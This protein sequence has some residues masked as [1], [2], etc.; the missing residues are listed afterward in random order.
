MGSEDTRG[1]S[2]DLDAM[3]AAWA[4]ATKIHPIGPI[5]TI[6]LDGQPA[7]LMRGSS[8]TAIGI[9][10][11]TYVQVTRNG[12]QFIIWFS[13]VGGAFGDGSHERWL[14]H[15]RTMLATWHWYA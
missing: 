1:E 11:R 9:E 15:F 12:L 5:R 14:P 6:T 4:A 13:V 2:T 3:A 10:D 7:T 8:L